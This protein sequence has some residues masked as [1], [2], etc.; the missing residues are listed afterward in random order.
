MADRRRA[1][2]VVIFAGG[3]GTRMTGSRVPKQFLKLGGTPVIAHTIAVFDSLQLIDRIVVVSPYDWIDHTKEVVR[4]KH[5]SKVL[6][7]V[8]GGKTGQES[9][10]AGVEALC[11]LAG[12]ADDDVVL[13]HDG[14]RP[15]IDHATVKACVRSVEERGATATISRSVET[16]IEQRDGRVERVLNRDVCMLARAP[17]GFILGDFRREHRRAVKEGLLDFVDS[18]SLMSYYGHEVFTVEGPSENIKITRPEDF[19]AFKGYSDLH[20]MKQ[21]WGEQ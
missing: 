20:E 2:D 17:Q 7:V 8:P 11:D 21:L 19:F 3:V 6:T 15:L 18:I 13:V 1:I 16:V 12:V 9:I 10:R 4:D 5:F 14:V